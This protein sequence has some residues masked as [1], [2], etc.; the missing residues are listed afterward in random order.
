ME[1]IIEVVTTNQDTIKD[2]LVFVFNCVTG[3]VFGASLLTAV[4]KT[5]SSNVYKLL[6]LAAI[7]TKN[8]KEEV[9]KPNY[10]KYK[11]R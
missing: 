5:K 4:T 3:T 8:V 1:T 6:E 10:N 2:I 9:K 7:V 11:K